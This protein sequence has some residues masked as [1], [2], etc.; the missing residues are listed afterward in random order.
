MPGKPPKPYSCGLD[1]ATSGKI[2]VFMSK[3]VSKPTLAAGVSLALTFT[4][5]TSCASNPPAQQ[6]TA[7]APT[8]QSVQAEP[9]TPQQAASANRGLKLEKEE[10][11][12]KVFEQASGIRESGNAVGENE[13]FGVN[14]A[15]LDARA[16][17]AQQLEV[18][19]NGLIRGFDQQHAS[20]QT[21]SSAAC[22]SA[23]AVIGFPNLFP[24][25]PRKNGCFG[26]RPVLTA[27]KSACGY[28]Q[29][30]G[31]FRYRKFIAVLLD[32]QELHFDTLEKM[33]TAFFKMAFS[34][35]ASL[36]CFSSSTLIC[37][38]LT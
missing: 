16:K 30:A 21:G 13:S 26:G 1:E 32:E 6:T 23:M 14:M 31:H 38:S 36:S 25:F 37:S 28:F 8:Y 4:I 5:L 19:V 3:T 20:G 33:P 29:D 17:L 7:T 24:Q 18:M 9:S 15:L 34:I 35:S 10:C 12:E 22:C 11:E 27:V 2:G